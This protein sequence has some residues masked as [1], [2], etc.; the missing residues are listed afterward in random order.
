MLT[1]GLVGA[2][3]LLLALTEFL[4][5]ND[6]Y[7]Q[8]MLSVWVLLDPVS[9]VCVIAIAMSICTQ[10]VSATQFAVYMSAANLGASSGS[11]LYAIVSQQVDFVQS[12]FLLAALL[13]FT[14][15]ILAMFRRP[16]RG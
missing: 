2:H 12:Y 14:L 6:V 7:V 16:S 4:W 9:M 3:A 10:G 13:A 1:I 11:K 8:T 15:C 5:V